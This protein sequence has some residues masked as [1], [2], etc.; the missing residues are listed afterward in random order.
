M[1]A[2]PFERQEI[3]AFEPLF[4]VP[5]QG[6]S[7][8]EAEA[9]VILDCP[10]GD[11]LGDTVQ[12]WVQNKPV[13]VID[14]HLGDEAEG[15]VLFVESGCPAAAILVYRVI[16]ALALEPTSQEADW[17]FL[18]LAADTGFFRFLSEGQDEAFL[19]AAALSR[20]GAS[21]RL[22]DRKVASGRSLESRRLLSRMLGR[23]E[24]L[25]GGS[26]LLTWQSLADEREFGQRR[27][28]D[29]LHHLMLTIAGVRAIAV[30]REKEDG[31]SISFR[32]VDEIDVS[33]VAATFGGGGHQKAAGAFIRKDLQ[34]A[35]PALRA[36]LL[37]IPS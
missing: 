24:A 33:R 37:A 14:H 25:Q 3:A 32:A 34:T 35:L 23:I 17:L 7:P 31:C 21:P 9:V 15:D 28:S 30:L 11:R 16:T 36:T 13:A 10:G 26:I 27:D 20:A 12:P 29:A 22:T 1:N 8:P 2:G 6:S 4:H 19:V 18:G 5:E